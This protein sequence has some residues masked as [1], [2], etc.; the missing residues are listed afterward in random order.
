MKYG[1]IIL[2]L[3]IF[4]ISTGLLSC[5]KTAPIDEKKFIKIYAEMIF[6]QDTSSL[7]ESD[8]KEKVLKKFTVNEND[9]DVT[10]KFYNNDP[11]KW[12]TFFD[13]T[14]SYIERSKPTPTKKTDLK[15]LPRQSLSL[16][17]KNL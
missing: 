6:M 15:S 9:Y 8:I 11:E 17:K 12:Q 16:D 1:S 13:S 2:Y 7:S 14:I 5:K 10:I 3:L 4:I